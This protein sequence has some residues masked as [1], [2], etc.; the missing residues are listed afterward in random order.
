M[1]HMRKLVNLLNLISNLFYSMGDIQ[2]SEIGYVKQVTL[3]ELMY[4][5]KSIEVSN[6]YFL[7]GVFYLQIKNYEKSAKCF[8]IAMIIRK[9]EYKD[10]NEINESIA[11]CQY[12]LGIVFK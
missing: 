10:D 2:H 11:D 12:N 3:F 7:M 4:G 9:R 8:E 5:S 6:Q 1:G